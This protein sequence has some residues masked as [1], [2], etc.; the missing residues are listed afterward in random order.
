MALSCR[1]YAL[2]PRSSN[3]CTLL[4][5]ISFRFL[6]SPSPGICMDARPSFRKKTHAYGGSKLH[7][8]LNVSAS[9]ARSSFQLPYCP[10][11]PIFDHHCIRYPCIRIVVAWVIVPCAKPS[12][13]G[14]LQKSP[15]SW[16]DFARS[17]MWRPSGARPA[18]E[19]RCV[20]TQSSLLLGV[21]ITPQL[22]D[23][24]SPTC[25]EP[26]CGTWHVNFFFF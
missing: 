13:R 1:K 9:R 5:A 24:M 26:V 23:K 12:S 15:R 14:H 17:T 21:S 11:D 6:R 25:H 16:E 2:F 22:R 20:R 19:G 18:P 8:I 10:R 7:R 3:A 4:G